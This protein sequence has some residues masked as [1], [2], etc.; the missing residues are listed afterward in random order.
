MTPLTPAHPA[1]IFKFCPKCGK[2]GFTFDGVKAFDCPYCHFRFYINAST[3]V[4]VILE[5]PS[6]EIVL[7]KR[8]NE[9]KAG[10]YDL[11]GGFV[12]PGESAEDAATREL[13]EELGIHVDN[14]RFIAS[15]PNEYIYRGITYYTT[16]I[17]FL[18]SIPQ[19][20]QLKP[21]DDVAEALIIHP[22]DV[23]FSTISF[24]SIVNMLKEHRKSLKIES[25]E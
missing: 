12:D 5:Y 20:T 9:P 7:S 11:P 25:N 6:G 19:D 16:D 14:L 3:A 10:S 21:A 22:K 8:K 18:A 23:D 1:N 13:Q 17:S 15:F 2:D 4:A 24:P